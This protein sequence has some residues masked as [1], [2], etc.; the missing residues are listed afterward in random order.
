VPKLPLVSKRVDGFAALEV[1]MSQ[2]AEKPF[3]VERLARIEPPLSNGGFG[4]AVAAILTELVTLLERFVVSGESPAAIDLRS[5][6]VSPQDLE[7]LQR[8]LGEGEVQAWANAAGLA[9]IREAR[10]SG[11][12]WVEH[13]DQ[14]GKLVAELIEVGRVPGV[15]SI[16]PAKITAGARDQRARINSAVAAS[17]EDV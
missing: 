7:E 6:P 14:G 2:L 5:L 17:L 1:H 8:V 11:I 13:Y 15:L 9:R 3:N 4:G 16:A 12:W 10:V